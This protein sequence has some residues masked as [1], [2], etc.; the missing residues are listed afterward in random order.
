MEQKSLKTAF[1]SVRP[2]LE[3]KLSSMTLSKDS[4]KIQQT[5]IEYL[6]R[7]LDENGE[8][9]QNLTM[10]EDYVLQAAISL[11]NAQQAMAGEFA[12][13]IRPASPMSISMN[14]SAKSTGLKSEQCPI[15]LGGTAVGGA[16][17]AMLLGKWGAVF[18]AIAG[19]ALVLYRAFRFQE[20]IDDES[21]ESGIPCEIEEPKLDTG[22]FLGIVSNICDSVD[23]LI[24][25]FR[26]QIN[27][28]VNKYESMEKPTIEKEYRFLLE[29]IQSLTGYKRTH[30]KSEDKYLEKL[31]TR[32]EDL[33]ETLEN[34]NLTLEDYTTENEQWFEKV[35]SDKTV[36]TRMVFPAVVKNGKDVVLQG[37]VFIPKN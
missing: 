27:K 17:G 12:N 4:V 21:E 22:V 19:T 37:K 6:N 26:S 15:A 14:E 2:E 24:E 33:A 3:A 7:L 28:V 11:L 32:I 35:V 13:N 31:Q 8:Y 5:I 20:T 9:R 36:E 25:T 16:A 1:E 23:S 29:S 18:G 30:D 34:Y 10:S